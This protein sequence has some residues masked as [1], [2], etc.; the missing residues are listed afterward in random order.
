MSLDI[1]LPIGLLFAI[2]GL[3]MAVFGIISSRWPIY[4]RSLGYNVNLWWGCVLLAFALF[5]LLMAR[6]AKRRAAKRDDPRQA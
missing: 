3:I 6:R 1:R 4:Q 5:M 2:I